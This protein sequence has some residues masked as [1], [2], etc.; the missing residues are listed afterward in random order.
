MSNLVWAVGASLAVSLISLIGIFTLIFNEKRLNE[1]LVLLIGFA[2]GGLIGGAF[3]HILP[4]ALDEFN[5]RG[6]FLYVILGFVSFFILERYFYWR[7]CHDGKCDIHPVTYLNL[8]GDGIHNLI[9]GVIIGT[10]FIVNVRFGLVAT[11]AIVF[12]EIPQEISDFGV[13]IYGGLSRFKALLYNYLFSLTAIVGA[14]AGYY[15]S[16][17]LKNFSGALLSF[18]AGG[19]IYIASC[20]LIPELHKEADLKKSNYTI[21]FFLLGLLFMF[22]LR[23]LHH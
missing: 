8:I 16:S 5:T 12:H 18:A 22:L 21:L 3:L 20:D 23:L 9:D 13:L 2:A 10:S 4:E 15:F 17:N 19:F 1:A 14:V 11:L 6:V 7:H